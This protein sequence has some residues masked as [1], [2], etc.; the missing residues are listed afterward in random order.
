MRQEDTKV[1]WSSLLKTEWPLLFIIAGTLIAGWIVYP[2]LPDQVA[3]HWNL[4]GEVDGYSSRAWGAFGLPLTTAA[5]YLLMLLLPSIDPKKRNYQKF[6]GAYRLFRAVMVVFMSGLY[7]VVVAS[8]LGYQLPV[9]RVVLT[10]VALLFIVMGNFMGQIR[11]NYF[12][13]IKTPWT[14]ANE[15]VWQKTH[16]IAA[17]LWVGAGLIGLVAA[18]AG[19]T[20]GAVLL[21]VSLVLAVVIPIVFSYL[22]YRRQQQ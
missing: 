20:A 5:I 10:G 3:S 2:Y 22:E 19:G 15:V 14:L 17:R 18:F 8:A 1:N 11:Q 4:K 21:G 7:G 12:V 6:T 9:G 16:R 13:G